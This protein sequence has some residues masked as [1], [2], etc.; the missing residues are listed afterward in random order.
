M[1]HSSAVRLLPGLCV[2]F[3]SCSDT[4]NG[5]AGSYV[6]RD[7]STMDG[8]PDTGSDADSS[9][10]DEETGPDIAVGILEKEVVLENQTVTKTLQTVLGHTIL[11]DDLYALTEGW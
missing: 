6:A 8:F 10:S 9:S 5:P 4:S 1:T 7:T 2:L 3:F 11:I